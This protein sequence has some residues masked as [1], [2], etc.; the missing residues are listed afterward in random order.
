MIKKNILVFV[1]VLICAAGYANGGL[2]GWKGIYGS[3]GKLVLSSQTV[4]LNSLNDE[5]GFNF[6]VTYPDA[7]NK[8]G[9]QYLYIT[10]NAVLGVEAYLM[11]NGTHKDE[12]YNYQVSANAFLLDVGYV[13]Y[14]NYHT[15]LTPWVGIGL[16]N[17]EFSMCSHE[18]TWI[19]A[20]DQGIPY[21]FDAKKQNMMLDFGI[22]WDLVYRKTS[23]GLHLSYMSPL[24]DAD[25][26]VA[27]EV[28]EEG[29][30]SNLTGYHLG[31]SIGFTDIDMW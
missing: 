19:Q 4:D 20:V 6:E 18:Q 8:Y 22:A 30:D 16:G 24:D 29:P 11:D 23:I 1:I 26:K 2:F 5:L 17:L 13:L 21:V 14:S 10:N 3:M 25:W 9:G 31:I 27:G 12:V 15:I 28:L 7:F